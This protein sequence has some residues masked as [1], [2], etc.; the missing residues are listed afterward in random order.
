MNSLRR[1]PVRTQAVRREASLIEV[2]ATEHAGEVVD[3]AKVGV[4]ADPFFGQRGMDRVVEVVIPL[5]VKP[6][7]VA[8]MRLDDAGII[9]VAFG[10]QGQ[11]SSKLRLKV[12]YLLGELFKEGNAEVSIMACTASSRRPSMW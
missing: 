3:A 12:P 11:M 6:I 5:R 7:P 2:G 1:P 4:I 10:D 8:F 9:E